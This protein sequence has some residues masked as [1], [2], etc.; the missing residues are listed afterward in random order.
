MVPFKELFK[1]EVIKSLKM[2]SEKYS[3]FFLE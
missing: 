2:R 1:N 3:S